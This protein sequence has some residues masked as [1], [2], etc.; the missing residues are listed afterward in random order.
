MKLERDKIATEYSHE[1][2]LEA[3]QQMP[4][5]DRATVLQAAADHA[6]EQEALHQMEED[7]QVLTAM[8]ESVLNFATNPMT[9]RQIMATSKTFLKTQ[10]KSESGQSWKDW[11]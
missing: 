7:D 4:I 10:R 9:M 3:S 5:E 8:D 2:I 11:R 6:A 1:N